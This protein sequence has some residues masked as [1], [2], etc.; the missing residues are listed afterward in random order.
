MKAL[1]RFRTAGIVTMVLMLFVVFS[2]IQADAAEYFKK[3]YVR[4]AVTAGETLAVGD[5][6]CIKTSD[7]YAYKADANDSA[8]RPA[9][10]VVKKGASSGSKAEIVIMGVLAGQSTASAGAR[11]FLSETAGALTTTAPTNAQPVG[12][13]MEGATAG[14]ESSTDYFIMIAIPSSAGAAY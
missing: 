4:F 14:D 12:F 10:G 5:V 11:V 13:V 6:A 7:G 1:K 3:A 9:V 8:L 2:A